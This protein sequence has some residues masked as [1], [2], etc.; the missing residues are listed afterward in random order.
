[1]GRNNVLTRS[2]PPVIA[3]V[4]ANCEGAES[5]PVHVLAAGQVG[6]VAVLIDPVAAPVAGDGAHRL[7][8]VVA[9]RAAH[10]RGDETVA[11]K[12]DRRA[13]P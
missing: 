1:M 9:V 6:A 7:D 2:S 3:V 13:G 4:T 12:P 8:R 11:V 5:V 10:H